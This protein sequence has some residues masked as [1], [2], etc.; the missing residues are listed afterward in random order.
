MVSA[1]SGVCHAGGN[2]LPWPAAGLQPKPRVRRDQEDHERNHR[3]IS[4]GIT[5][6]IGD[7]IGISID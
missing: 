1:A 4:I 7:F 3:R 2:G 6:G 5:M